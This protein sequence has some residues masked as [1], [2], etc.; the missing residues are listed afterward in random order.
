MQ[1]SKYYPAPIDVLAVVGLLIVA[2]AWM[3]LLC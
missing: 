1:N 2:W 3:W